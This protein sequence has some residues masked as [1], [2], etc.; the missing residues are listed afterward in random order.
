MKKLKEI[1]RKKIISENPA[2]LPKTESVNPAE[3]DFGGLQKKTK[4]STESRKN[5]NADP[6]L[7]QGNEL[8]E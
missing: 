1:F 2:G 5:V 8:D 4:S 3:L 6:N 7:I